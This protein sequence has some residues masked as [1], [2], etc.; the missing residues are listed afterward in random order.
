MVKTHTLAK[1]LGWFQFL[2][3]T[4]GTVLKDGVPHGAGGWLGLLGS[5]GM[6]IGIHAASS[7]DGTK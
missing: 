2:A 4:A 5:L 1:I 7:T 3:T 6:A